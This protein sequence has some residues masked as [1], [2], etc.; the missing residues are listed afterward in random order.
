[1]RDNLYLYPFEVKVVEFTPGQHVRPKRGG[2]NSNESVLLRFIT[3]LDSDSGD[4]PFGRWPGCFV[5]DAV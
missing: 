2:D 3:R 4:F 1:V 5:N